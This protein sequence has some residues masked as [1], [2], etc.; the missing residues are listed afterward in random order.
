MAL[1]YRQLMGL[2]L[3]DAVNAY[4]QRDTMLYALGV[5]LG[6]DPMDERQLRFVYEE[7]L[8]AMPSM[9]VAKLS[10]LKLLDHSEVLAPPISEFGLNA[11]AII[12][13]PG[14]STIP[15][16]ISAAMWKRW[17]AGPSGPRTTA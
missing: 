4:T 12:H 6:A 2:T 14:Y 3:P 11:E 16:R 13:R 8:K 5:G 17:T 10:K 1:N 9:A 15:V 7:G